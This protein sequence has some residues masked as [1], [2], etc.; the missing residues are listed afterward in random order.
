[1]T[2]LFDQIASGE[3]EVGMP[4]KG[5][6]LFD[7]IASGQVDVQGKP[8]EVGWM[9]RMGGAAKAVGGSLLSAADLAAS[10]AH[11]VS[12][13]PMQLGVEAMGQIVGGVMPGITGKELRHQWGEQVGGLTLQPGQ[14]TELFTGQPATQDS[15][16]ARSAEMLGK[17]F[18]FLVPTKQLE[19]NISM[20]K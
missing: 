17:G 14:L 1:M 20:M 4:S 18:E 7:R 12:M 10:T 8:P 13:F 15:Q 5:G 2:S 9:E 19:E 16:I 3:V 11:G 6:S